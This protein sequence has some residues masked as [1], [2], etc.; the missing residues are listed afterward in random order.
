MIYP[1][2]FFELIPCPS[3]SS[4]CEYISLI[5][6]NLVFKHELL[7]GEVVLKA[8]DVITVFLVLDL[9]VAQILNLLL[10]LDDPV[11]LGYKI[12]VRLE[13]SGIYINPVSQS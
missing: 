2:K 9:S 13:F 4:L 5:G 6:N 7:L 1:L 12:F 11:L 3:K 10:L 8:K